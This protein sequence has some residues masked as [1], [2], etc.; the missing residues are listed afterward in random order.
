MNI[1]L[2]SRVEADPPPEPPL[3]PSRRP[4]QAPRNRVSSGF[5]RLFRFL[6]ECFITSVLRRPSSGDLTGAAVPAPPVHDTTLVL[7]MYPTVHSFR[8]S[9]GVIATA[10]A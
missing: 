7:T 10:E 5:R 2:D 3:A 4:T 1:A 9:G 8:T 6:R